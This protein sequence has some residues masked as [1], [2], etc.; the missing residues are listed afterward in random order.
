MTCKANVASDSI[1]S[2]TFP[3]R[4]LLPGTPWTVST[5]YFASYAKRNIEP[6]P[7][8]R[9]AS[10]PIVRKNDD[11][12][13]LVVVVNRYL[14]LPRR[15]NVARREKDGF[16]LVLAHCIAGHKEVRILLWVRLTVKKN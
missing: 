7:S 8:P 6:V 13:N 16:T 4:V 3:A 9:T 5:H 12:G 11:L 14:P 10:E 2:Y 15:E 1:P